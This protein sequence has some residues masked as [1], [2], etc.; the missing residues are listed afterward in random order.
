MWIFSQLEEVMRIG[1]S[2]TYTER[3]SCPQRVMNLVRIL[4]PLL[5]EPA[6]VGNGLMVS[7]LGLYHHS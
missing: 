2:P 4:L 3:V 5:G 7:L 6:E 1:E